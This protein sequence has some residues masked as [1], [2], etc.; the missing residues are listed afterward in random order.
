MYQGPLALEEDY[1]E[2]LEWEHGPDNDR[3]RRFWRYGREHKSRLTHLPF[4]SVTQFFLHLQLSG[5]YRLKCLKLPQP[6]PEFSKVDP[7]KVKWKGRGR[8]KQFSSLFVDRT[9]FRLDASWQKRQ[10]YKLKIILIKCLISSKRFIRCHRK[11]KQ[12][13]S[14][15]QTFLPRKGLRVDGQT[16]WKIKRFTKI[17]LNW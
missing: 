6:N 14:T 1:S 8:H 16:N 4:F 17:R 5:Q 3:Y 15:S 13:P 2:Q 7:D 10:H 12:N 11:Q 9:R